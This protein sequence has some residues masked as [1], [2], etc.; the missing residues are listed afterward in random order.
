M[1]RTIVCQPCCVS[2]FVLRML[3]SA[4]LFTP[5]AAPASLRAQNTLITVTARLLTVRAAAARAAP[6]LAPDQPR[7]HSA[8]P[9]SHA[10]SCSGGGG[11]ALPTF[12][13]PHSTCRGLGREHCTAAGGRQ[14]LLGWAPSLTMYPLPCP[15]LC[16]G[17]WMSP[18]SGLAAQRLTAAPL[19]GGREQV[20]LTVDRNSCT[21]STVPALPI[22]WPVSCTSCLVLHLADS[23]TSLSR[24]RALP[25]STAGHRSEAQQTQAQRLTASNTADQSAARGPDCRT[26]WPSH[27]VAAAPKHA[28]LSSAKGAKTHTC[29][30]LC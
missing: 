29:A 18:A 2:A 1:Q 9:F 23:N 14:T 24:T 22:L 12:Q 17:P 13:V 28:A 27:T 21:S 11:S 10:C 19:G 5:A 30:L 4:S 25:T 3:L 7:T 8:A 6:W 26:Q 15:C 20:K 16:C